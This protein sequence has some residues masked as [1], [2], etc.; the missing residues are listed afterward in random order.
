[1]AVHVRQRIQSRIATKIAVPVIAILTAIF[2]LVIIL[3]SVLTGRT[4]SAAGEREMQ[5]I[6]EKNA[7]IFQGVFDSVNSTGEGIS[8]YLYSE[9]DG[10]ASYG[11]ASTQQIEEI[12]YYSP[13]FG[14]ACTKSTYECEL[15]LRRIFEANVG[16]NGAI[17][18]MG[19]AF[20]P[21]SFDKNIESFSM[22]VEQ[23]AE[24]SRTSIYGTYNA[25]S[26]ELF[27]T[28]TKEAMQPITTPV[29]DY[30]G[31]DIVTATY[32]IIYNNELMGV[33]F[34]DVNLT[35]L[36]NQM[37]DT[38]IHFS[39]QM[40]A[41]VS[42]DGAV[43]YSSTYDALEAQKNV[44]ED[45]TQNLDSVQAQLHGDE[46]FSLVSAKN[47]MFSFVPIQVSGDTWWAMTRVD[48]AELNA[49]STA[50]ILFLVTLMVVALVL[51]VAMI[52]FLIRRNLRPIAELRSNLNL[53][54]KG[55]LSQMDVQYRS[56]DELGQLADDLR[57]ASN[58][59]KA[60]IQDQN[61]VLSSFAQGDFSAQCQATS[62]YVGEL[63]GMHQ[64]ISQVS[65][66]LS[67]A[68][69]EIDN[70]ANQVAAGADQV[71]SGAQALSQGATEQA[72]SVEELAATVQDI[73]QQ[74]NQNAA[75]I[76]EANNETISAGEQLKF[77]SQKMRE[78]IGAMDEIKQTSDQIKGIIKTIDDIAFQT[79][80]L[81]LN[82]AVEAARAGAAGKGFA[83]VADEVR[84]LAGKSAEAS[85]STQELIQ[86]SI[87]A[88][89]SGSAMAADTG[90]V[91]DE[92][93]EG[94][95][96]VVSAMEDVSRAS[97]EQADN[98]SQVTQGLDQISAVVQT[99]SA[100]AEESAAASQEL[101]GQASLLKA[102]IGRFR[103]AGQESQMPYLD[104]PVPETEQGPAPDACGSGNK[105]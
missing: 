36:S 67:D 80:I 52:I 17:L 92:T 57:G 31:T 83:V 96:L 100:T 3:T 35:Y 1:M 22:M 10:S 77:S 41:V 105:Y 34:A 50:L 39:T 86:K 14:V 43:Q 103:F 78:L 76:K 47:Q 18:N 63:Q 2:L 46:M 99:N 26:Q 91:L 61:T 82:A 64:A 104:Q 72:S 70:A 11:T 25:Y 21:Y 58:T 74:I 30:N 71:S 79:N 62:Y 55:M 40:S 19:A 60:V 56:G 51:L 24:G 6:A 15:V 49:Q 81:A 38:T 33:I 29:Y 75:H 37:Q 66:S 45:F 13:L 20:E 7:A 97:T 32:P 69:R 65:Q 27:Y 84:S 42:P 101:S 44:L 93:V 94:V 95:A 59:L 88:V 102:L 98:I 8:A 89:D 85:R 68:F 4:M 90:K 87:R 16:N 48:V 23:T 73:S 53:L 12:Q 28:M 5:G 9:Y 54:G